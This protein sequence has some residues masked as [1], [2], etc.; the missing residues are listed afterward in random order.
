[1][2]LKI[3]NKSSGYIISEGGDATQ[4]LT[5]HVADSETTEEEDFYGSDEEVILKTPQDPIT[6]KDIRELINCWEE[7]FKKITEGVRALEIGMH[8]VHTH[9]DVVMRENRTRENAQVTTNKQ[10]KSIQEALAHFMDTYDPARRAPV[11]IAVKSC[12][13]TMDTPCVRT[14]VE[15]RAATMS[16]PITPPG[17]PPK[18]RSEFSLSPVN[19]ATPA[20]TMRVDRGRD[21]NERPTHESGNGIGGNTQITMN[22]SSAMNNTATR[23]ASSPKLPIFDGTVSAHFRPWLIQFEAIARHQCWTSGEKVVHLVASLTGPAANM[24]IGM[25]M[26]QLD[27]YAFLAARLSHRYDPPEREEAHR[28]ELRVRTRCRN[29]SADEFAENLKN[30]AQRAYPN[31][32]QNM[33]DNLVVERFREGHNNI[34]LNKHLCLYPLQDLIGACVRFELGT[35]AYKP[36][37]GMYTVKGNDPI[38][39]SF[40]EVARAAHANCAINYAHG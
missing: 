21:L 18:F 16:T 24:L 28:A 23:N 2:Y 13:P 38:E 9:L 19:Q 15:P 14:C 10:M 30:L 40:D 5:P 6:R 11:S 17:A 3:W 26:G 32:D 36:N 22:T 20:E 8:D 27:D 25:T 4:A 34:E 1:M 7:K 37:E 31:A 29:E 33:L 39:L 35:R 12:A